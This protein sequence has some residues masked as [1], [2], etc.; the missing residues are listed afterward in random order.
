MPISKP[1][2]QTNHTPSA[3]SPKPRHQNNHR[4]L[5][6]A[7]KQLKDDRFKKG[8]CVWCG[9]KY[10][11][12]HRCTRSQLFQLLVEEDSLNQGDGEAFM[13]CLASL[14]VQWRRNGDGFLGPPCHA[15]NS[16]STELG[17]RTK[18]TMINKYKPLYN[19]YFKTGKPV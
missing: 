1:N 9:D 4:Y 18:R 7:Q 14:D 8:L 12:D 5:T 13:D 6:P 15:P 16:A 19:K 17:T 11:K 3:P 10:S 2:S